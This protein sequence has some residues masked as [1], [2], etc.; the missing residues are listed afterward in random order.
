[1]SRGTIAK[2]TN[3]QRDPDTQFRQNPGKKKPSP[4]RGAPPR[5]LRDGSLRCL[6]APSAQLSLGRLLPSI[7][8]LLFT[9]QAQNT[10]IGEPSQTPQRLWALASPATKK[11]CN[12]SLHTCHN[13]S[14]SRLFDN[15][16][17][18]RSDSPVLD[19][20]ERQ[21]SSRPAEDRWCRVVTRQGCVSLLQL[22]VRK[23]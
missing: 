21:P 9:R 10:P 1:L 13:E 5:G 2:A 16:A 23:E 14:T 8:G 18:G 4:R 17:P 7:A 15:S 11:S 20:P 6:E 22:Q 3:H 12:V 19:R